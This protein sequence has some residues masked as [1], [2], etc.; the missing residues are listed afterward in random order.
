MNI[1]IDCLDDSWIALSRGFY[2]E[3]GSPLFLTDEYNKR[4]QEFKDTDNVGYVMNNREYK[5]PVLNRDSSIIFDLLVSSI[6][7]E[8]PNVQASCIHK[9]VKMKYAEP[10]QKLLNED[11]IYSSIIGFILTIICATSFVLWD[12]YFSFNTA[13]IAMTVI[14][15]SASII[16]AL[17]IKTYK[18]FLKLF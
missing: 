8:Q 18:L 1:R 17:F 15:L 4:L 9:S 16:G 13:V 10:R 2:D 7:N 6:D 11:L 3:N 5:V 12:D 14:A